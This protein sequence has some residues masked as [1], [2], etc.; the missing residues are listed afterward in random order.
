MLFLESIAK[1][2]YR[3]N[4]ENTHLGIIAWFKAEFN[5]IGNLVGI[6]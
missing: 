3:A 4:K 5:Y 2:N 6:I 1:K